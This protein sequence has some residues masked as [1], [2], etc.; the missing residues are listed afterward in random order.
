MFKQV[1]SA[2]FWYYLY[3]FRRRVILISL[4]LLIA[5]FANSIYSD[6]VQYL[7][8]QNQLQ[9]LKY[10]LTIKWIVI[11][12]SVLLSIYLILTIFKKQKQDEK[13][14][15]T[16]SN[17]KQKTDKTLSSRE[18]SFLNKKELKSEAEALLDR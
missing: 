14:D 2:F 10:V 4:L 9:Y 7:Q 15:K 18:E 17:M 11:L 5:I 3:K 12:S 8:L 1:K 6:V 16:T 13:K